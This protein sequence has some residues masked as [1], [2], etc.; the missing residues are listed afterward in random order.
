MHRSAQVDSLQEVQL[1]INRLNREE[2]WGPDIEKISR[3]ATKK[4]LEELMA[5]SIDRRLHELEE[6]G[7]VDRR[8]GYYPRH[9]LTGIGD[10]EVFVPR[11]RTFSAKAV[12]EA[13]V[14]RTK[15]VD[16]AILSCFV[17]GL[18]TRKVGQA[19]QPMLGE[20][21][22]PTTVSRIAK[23]LDRAVEAFHQRKLLHRY[24]A[25]VLDGVV[26]SRK[27]GA[28]AVKRP[29]LVALGILPDGRKEVLDFRLSK[30]ESAAEWRVLL[31]SLY[32]R[33]LAEKDLEVIIVDGGAGLLSALPEVYPD[34]RIQRCWAHKVRNVTDKVRKA[35]REKVKRSLQQIY[36]A[37]NLVKARSA[38]R[39]FKERWEEKYPRAV[40]CLRNDLNELLTCF[41]ISKD[42]DWRRQIRTTN[43]IERRFREVRRRTRP[44]G[45]FSDRTSMERILFAVFTN[46]NQNQNVSTLFLVTQSS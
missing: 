20:R 45:V 44:M 40:R 34:V 14:R 2:R 25:L 8:N 42:E 9:I 18:S 22:S 30:S 41:H 7:M 43:A 46:E 27:T 38:A 31:T 4:V 10:I 19:L 5:C 39:R 16:R 11:T 6:R 28:G 15:D 23:T 29:V 35:D 17:L 32:K 33:G 3:E 26:L 36:N 12:L 21:V 37:P 1:Y 24:R 13:Y